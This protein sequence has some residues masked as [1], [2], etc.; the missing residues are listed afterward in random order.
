MS[1]YLTVIDYVRKLIPSSAT[2]AFMDI[3][4]KLD[5]EQVGELNEEGRDAL[6]ELAIGRAYRRG[7]L[8][9]SDILPP[10]KIGESGDGSS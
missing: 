6:A 9:P 4:S 2:P 1:G 5:H 8:L 7:E 3:I 10:F